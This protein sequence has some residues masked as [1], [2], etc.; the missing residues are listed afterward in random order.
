MLSSHR[1]S[2]AFS[3]Y[4]VLR[5]ACLPPL[6]PPPQPPH[7]NL[8]MASVAL[9]YDMISALTCMGDLNMPSYPSTDALEF[10][11][12][13]TLF[14]SSSEQA[15][16]PPLE[17][18]FIDGGLKEFI[19]LASTDPSTPDDEYADDDD[20]STDYDGDSD[21]I[22][23]FEDLYELYAEHGTFN[24]SLPA[25]PS[26]RAAPS[27]HMDADAS[28]SEEGT[29]FYIES[30]DCNFN[31]A[32]INLHAVSAILASW[33]EEHEPPLERKRKRDLHDV[34]G[35]ERCESRVRQIKAQAPRIR[36]Q[37]Q[38]QQPQPQPL[39]QFR[40]QPHLQAQTHSP[41]LS[42][43]SAAIRQRKPTPYPSKLRAL[44]AGGA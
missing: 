35:E 40:C 9:C 23:S 20:D 42:S 3:P 12:A 28:F 15:T 13:N 41:T 43:R 19:R 33:I 26:E 30:A 29:P 21:S 36:P 1:S 7:N 18:V 17:H 22:T 24:F 11:T 14:S 5:L 32:P 16:L 6:Q 38:P 27:T 8:N 44:A 31:I 37:S 2:F 39:V 4:L 25:S 10:P 34:G